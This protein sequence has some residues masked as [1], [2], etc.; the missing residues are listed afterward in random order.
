MIAIY[1]KIYTWPSDHQSLTPHPLE[2]AP[3]PQSRGVQS[4]FLLGRR[5]TECQSRVALARAG[6]DLAAG[7]RAA[8]GP[9]N[10]LALAVGRHDLDAVAC[11]R[12]AKDVGEV[13]PQLARVER[14]GKVGLGLAGVEAVALARDLERAAA[15]LGVARVLLRVLAAAGR[16]RV[17]AGDAAADGPQRHLKGAVVDDLGLARGGGGGGGGSEASDGED[18]ELIEHDEE[19]WGYF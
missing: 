17:G 7:G 6:L 10:G 11:K 15:R 19:F 13:V 2:R 5:S 12:V 9:D 1:Y 8:V 16:E 4:L 18:A 3:L 14:V